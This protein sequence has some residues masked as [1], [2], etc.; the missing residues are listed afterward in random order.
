DVVT[1]NEAIRDELQAVCYGIWDHIKNSGEFDADTLTLEWVG[2]VP[3]KREY[4]R[5]VGDH[6]LTQHDVL[7]QTEFEDR[8]AF[9]GWSIDLHPAGG[10]Y[11]SEPGSRHWYSDGV[12]HI[13][14]RSLYSRNVSNMWMAGRDISATHVAFGTTRVMAT[15]AVIGE[16]AGLAAALGVQHDLSPRELA[17]ESFEVVRRALVRTDASVV[18]V[19]HS[20]PADHALT[21]AVTTSST[22]ASIVVD[23]PAATHEL[24]TPLGIVLPVHPELDGLEVLLDSEGA[25][26]LVVELHATSMPQNYLPDSLLESM[27]VPVPDGEKQWVTVPLR[28]SP[29]GDVCNA[30]IVIRGEGLRAH[31]S[32]DYPSG[33]LAYRLR[34]D[35]PPDA[36]QEWRPWKP[37]EDRLVPCLRV[38]RTEAYRASNVV[39]GYAR[40]YGGPQLWSSQPLSQDPAPR[41]ELSWSEPAEFG[42]VTLV[43]DDDVDLD[44]INLH[45]H[46][47]EREIIP[48]LVR[49]YRLEAVMPDGGTRVLADVTDNRVRHRRHRFDE[50]VTASAVRLVV[51]TTNGAPCA[52]V[53]SLRAWRTDT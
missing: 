53:V 41:L 36:N 22:L 12:Y 3:G 16:A 37:Y 13:P 9:G 52:H 25:R 21:A 30:F 4:R 34:N 38:E 43:L 35:P 8:V 17:G 1:D 33:L 10:V 40:P 18:G 14:L 49:D 26:D 2:S 31:M 47:T 27:T 51:T 19:E 45:H 24:S 23:S 6:V 7:G 50:P 5:F 32:A 48:T 29:R 42:E 46:T 20:D 28:W 44:L 11:A 39:G 15:C